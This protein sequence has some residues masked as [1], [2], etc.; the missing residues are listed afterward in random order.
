MC[1]IRG[2]FSSVR[3][4]IFHN[5]ALAFCVVRSLGVALFGSLPRSPSGMPCRLSMPSG[6][7]RKLICFVGVVGA[8]FRLLAAPRSPSCSRC[9]GCP[10]PLGCSRSC[11]CANAPPLRLAHEKQGFLFGRP[12]VRSPLRSFRC[13]AP[14]LFPSR[15]CSRSL[16]SRSHRHASNAGAPCVLISDGRV[17]RVIPRLRVAVLVVYSSSIGTLSVPRCP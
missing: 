15:R 4:A 5:S 12:A 7:L 8:P 16:R 9:A 13:G 10:F 6:M 14:L 1:A 11:V 17:S 2:R 3:L